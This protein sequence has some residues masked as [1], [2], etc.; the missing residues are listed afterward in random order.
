MVPMSTIASVDDSSPLL[1]THRAEP[2]A[3]DLWSNSSATLIFTTKM[4]AMATKTPDFGMHALINTLSCRKSAC[5]HNVECR[6]GLYSVCRE[7]LSIQSGCA[8]CQTFH[9]AADRLNPTIR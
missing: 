7:V 6:T 9:A 3:I 1:E 8:L 2:A 5:Q 4:A